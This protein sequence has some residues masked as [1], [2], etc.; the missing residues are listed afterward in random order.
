MRYF[1]FILSLILIPPAWGSFDFEEE[2]GDQPETRVLGQF[3]RGQEQIGVELIQL[4]DDVC[5]EVLSSLN[6]KGRFADVFEGLA[7]KHRQQIWLHV[8]ESMSQS[9]NEDIQGVVMKGMPRII[10]LNFRDFV[11]DLSVIS[12]ASLQKNDFMCWYSSRLPHPMFSYAYIDTPIQIPGVKRLMDW[13]RVLENPFYFC[14]GLRE[15]TEASKL[16]LEEEGLTFYGYMGG[17]CFD[18][19]QALPE[20]MAPMDCEISSVDNVAE[21]HTF[22]KVMAEAAGIDQGIGTK[23]F[24]DYKAFKDSKFIALIARMDGRPVGCSMMLRSSP[25]VAGNYFD[26]VLGEFRH[27]G[28]NTAM[29]NMRMH[30]AKVWG[31]RFL[32]AQ[33][34]DSSR[35]LYEKLGFKRVCDI[36]LFCKDKW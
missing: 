31:H 27:K 36:G 4:T 6:G 35:G 9:H 5:L 16:L 2:E 19:R 30:L 21:Y 14:T 28:I 15:S 18:L 17:M 22:A 13:Y 33:C 32:V 8:M 3:I 1:I 25:M 29:V 11:E 20:L 26:W 23:F 7:E 10:S 12:G 34:M 24:K